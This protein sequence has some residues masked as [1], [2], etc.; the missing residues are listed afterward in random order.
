MARYGATEYRLQQAVDRQGHKTKYWHVLVNGRSLGKIWKHEGGW[1][2][3]VAGQDTTGR[4]EPMRV[5]A[6]EEVLKAA[7]KGERVYLAQR[8]ALE[9][10]LEETRKRIQK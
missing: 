2:F 10:G 8:A 5:R 7:V 9:R 1:S 6:A 3:S 4:G